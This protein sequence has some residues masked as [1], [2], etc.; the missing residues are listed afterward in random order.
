MESLNGESCLNGE[1]LNGERNFFKRKMNKVES[2]LIENKGHGLV[3]SA[4]L[5]AKHTC[6]VEAPIV[7]I[8]LAENKHKMKLSRNVSSGDCPYN[9]ID[10]GHILVK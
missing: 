6:V 2:R 7:G 3:A 9:S 4:Q 5:P 8:Q 1:C 10:E